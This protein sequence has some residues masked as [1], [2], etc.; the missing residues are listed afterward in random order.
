MNTIKPLAVVVED[1]EE[2]AYIFVK[3]LEAAGF[4]TMVI[5]NGL[6]ARRQ[7]PELQPSLI[8]LDLQLPRVSGETLLELI[9]TDERLLETRVILVTAE[10]QAASHLA[11]KVDLI[12]LKPVAF[13]QLRDLA[14]RM[15][16]S[17]SHQTPRS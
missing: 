7:L 12:L 1:H 13:D 3:A 5:R 2:M 14:E 11:Q 4:A 15:R 8:A 16:S 10:Q 17:L 6:E 9:H